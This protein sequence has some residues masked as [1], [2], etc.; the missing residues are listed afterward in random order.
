MVSASEARGDDLN[1]SYVQQA[2]KHEE[3][4]RVSN[5]KTDSGKFSSGSDA[6]LIGHQ[7]SF[8]CYGCGKVDIYDETSLKNQNQNGT[9]CIQAKYHR[10]I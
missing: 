4:K 3:L 10:I 9:L 2:L 7:R 5:S 1:L 8:K 6:V